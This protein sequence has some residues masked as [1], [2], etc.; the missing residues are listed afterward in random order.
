MRQIVRMLLEIASVSRPHKHKVYKELYPVVDT[1]LS[2]QGTIA[3]DRIK[4]VM[5]DSDFPLALGEYVNRALWPAYTRMEFNYQQLVFNDTLPNFMTVTRYQRQSGLDDLELIRPKQGV[6]SG[7]LK[8]AYK[9]Q[10]KVYRWGKGFDFSYEALVNDDLGYFR[11][12][13]ELMGDAARRS[14]EKFVSRL[15]FNTT[16]IAGLVA[17]GVIYSGTARLSTNALMVGWSAFDQR[18]DDRS[19]PIETAP[20][21]L[22]IHKALQPTARQIFASTQ[23]AEN[24]TNAANV[25][26]PFNIVVDPYM[27]G[28][29]PNYP[30]YLMASPNLNGIRPITLARMQG[31]PGPQVLQKAP[32]TMAFA[33]F[34]QTGQ[35]V[36]GLG[37]F[38]SGDI[39]LKVEDVWGG[40]N[41]PTYSGVTDYRGVYYSSGTTS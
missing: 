24:N 9:R 3:Q 20:V 31:R 19:E 15:Y 37:D 18:L 33:G 40:W 11:D 4:E 6:S 26:P 28:T 30:W 38:D 32:D 41:D 14:I 1:M 25:L 36:N 39:K 35:L 34:G 27:T 12:F 21:N 10:Y 16:T 5:T 29:A 22:V 17:L 7:Y 8:D 23:V 2:G 13:A